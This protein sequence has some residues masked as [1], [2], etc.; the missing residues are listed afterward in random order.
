MDIAYLGPSNT[1][2]HEAARAFFLNVEI[3]L[4]PH[5]TVA[6]VLKAVSDGPTDY[7]VVPIENS[8][9][10]EIA[11][12]MDAL[13]F[14]YSSL[15][16]CGEVIIPVSFCAFKKHNDSINPSKV[17]SHPHALSQCRQYIDQ[18]NLMRIQS[19][20]TADACE[21]VANEPADGVIAI[22]SRTAGRAHGLDVV[23]E[24][25]EDFKG[26]ATKFIAVGRKLSKVTNKDRTSLVLLPK[27]QGRGI[28]AS[29]LHVVSDHDVDLISLH[30]RPVKRRLETYCFVL[31]ISGHIKEAKVNSMLQDLLKSGNRLKVLGSYPRWTESLNSDNRQD[32]PTGFLSLSEYLNIYSQTSELRNS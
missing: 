15:L 12:T 10:G 22:A 31:T 14:D 29:L 19:K 11:T 28:L 26:A 27:D 5:P 16:I 1:F 6:S 21:I 17:I 4:T 8:V 20:S 3:E 9:Q 23:A 7:G 24:E 25:I 32:T 13:I 30:S 18:L 2:T